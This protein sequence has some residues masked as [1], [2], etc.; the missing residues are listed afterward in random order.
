MGRAEMRLRAAKVFRGFRALLMEV[1]TESR[2]AELGGE[3]VFLRSQDGVRRA[4]KDEVNAVIDA[5]EACLISRLGGPRVAEIQNRIAVMRPKGVDESIL[6]QPAG[7]RPEH[8]S[9]KATFGEDRRNPVEVRR[10]VE[11][12]HQHSGQK[13]LA[14]GAVH[15]RVQ[16]D[17]HVVALALLVNQSSELFRWPLRIVFEKIRAVWRGAEMATDEPQRHDWMGLELDFD[18]AGIASHSATAGQTRRAAQPTATKRIVR[19]RR[20]CIRL[21]DRQS[22]NYSHTEAVTH[23]THKA[24]I[25]AEAPRNIKRAYVVHRITHRMGSIQ[26]FPKCCYSL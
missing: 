24:A 7:D 6:Q 10:D 11:I 18:S 3:M 12:A 25:R 1:T 4:H 14:S 2:R 19:L 20:K 26:I 22:T 15:D 5:L 9:A 16:N 13:R 21:E 8:G 23:A 17:L